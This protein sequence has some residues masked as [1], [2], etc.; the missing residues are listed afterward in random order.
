MS[1]WSPEYW[2]EMFTGEIAEFE[3][4]IADFNREIKQ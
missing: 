2:E 3:K 4:L 1:L